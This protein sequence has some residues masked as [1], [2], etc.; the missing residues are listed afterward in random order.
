MCL[1]GAGSVPGLEALAPG[2]LVR[3]LGWVLSPVP[4]TDPQ[5]R[6]PSEHHHHR[7]GCHRPPREA[8][9]I[10]LREGRECGCLG[11]GAGAGASCPPVC[12]GQD[13]V[14]SQVTA[15]VEARAA[16][17]RD[18]APSP[19]CSLPL[20]ARGF[21]PSPGAPLQHGT[22]WGLTLL[23]VATHLPILLSLG[24]RGV[25]PHPAH[26][27]G[28]PAW[29]WAYTRA[30]TQMHPCMHMHMEPPLLHTHLDPWPRHEHPRS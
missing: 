11:P 15:S 22:A 8:H 26:P 7:R 27:L 28:L 3:C 23:A 29:K 24:P 18:R 1:W 19:C 5:P 13:V 30:H 10:Q 14:L 20:G 21:C 16:G 9:L 6:L 4:V 25:R 12:L 17:L 2:G